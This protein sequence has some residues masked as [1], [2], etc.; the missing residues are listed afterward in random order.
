[1]IHPFQIRPAELA[2]TETLVNFNVSMAR[3]T[4]E[5]ELD[6]SVVSSGVKSLLERPE[7]GFYLV[8]HLESKRVGCLM[9]TYEWS[10]WRNAFFWWIQ[11]VYVAPSFRRQGVFRRLYE[12]VQSLA[13][14][15]SDVCG[16]RLYV[17]QDNRTAQ[18]TYQSLGMIRSRYGIFECEFD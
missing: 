2:D 9:V 14:A 5:K 16:L 11:S 12:H 10:D 13:E 8:A 3:E 4:E 7:A 18:A 15:R 6:R 17:D 1:M